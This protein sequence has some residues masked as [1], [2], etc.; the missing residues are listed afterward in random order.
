LVGLLRCIDYKR[1]I[2][3]DRFVALPAQCVADKC[4][5]FGRPPVSRMRYLR[6]CPAVTRFA[7]VFTGRPLS[8]NH[9]CCPDAAGSNAPKSWAGV[10]HVA[11]YESRGLPCSASE[12][13]PRIKPIRS[14]RRR[15]SGNAE[16][17]YQGILHPFGGI[18]VTRSDNGSVSTIFGLGHATIPPEDQPEQLFIHKTAACRKSSTLFA[19][20]T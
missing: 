4:A 15:D 13:T 2:V 17:V 7:I 3:A 14:R 8:K 18:V 19:S 12:Q 6:A 9:G 10:F 20:S 16:Y 1:L 5:V 11:K